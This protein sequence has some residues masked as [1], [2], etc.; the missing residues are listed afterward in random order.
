[1]YEALYDSHAGWRISNSGDFDI[2]SGSICLI[3]SIQLDRDWRGQGISLLAVEGL[4][5]SSCQPYHDAAVLRAHPSED[6][7]SLGP[8]ATMHKLA[9]HWALLGFEPCAI[10]IDDD[11]KA[12][13]MY[14]SLSSL[15]DSNLKRAVPHLLPRTRSYSRKDAVWKDD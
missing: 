2:G 14:M 7:G 9:N 8:K 10:M 12:S 6:A 4:I 3:H 13:D 1:M 5:R 15:H 11:E